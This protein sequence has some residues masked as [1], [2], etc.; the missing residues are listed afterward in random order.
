MSSPGDVRSSVMWRMSSPGDARVSMIG[1][2]CQVS[3]DVYGRKLAMVGRAPH[4]MGLPERGCGLVDEPTTDVTVFSYNSQT[5]NR[6]QAACPGRVRSRS[7][8][9]AAGLCRVGCRVPLPDD[10]ESPPRATRNLNRT[11]HEIRRRR[12]LARA[13]AALDLVLEPICD[14]DRSGPMTSVVGSVHTHR[15][16]VAVFEP[17]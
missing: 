5:S 3:P 4:E 16:N 8:G 13:V 6:C 17:E 11:T 2:L 10:V 15:S 1:P 9:R 12:W 7:C 14:G